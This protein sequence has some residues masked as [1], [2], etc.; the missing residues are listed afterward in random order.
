MKKFTLSILCV[1]S[2][3]FFSCSKEEIKQQKNNKSVTAEKNGILRFSSKSDL[4]NQLAEISKTNDFSQ[5]QKWHLTK[6]ST[7]G[8]F[9]SLRDSLISE[10]LSKLSIDDINQMHVNGLILDPEDS[11]IADP[12]FISVLNKY[13]TIIVG[14]K[15]Y[16][17]V[18][19]GVLVCDEKDVSI[20]YS[21]SL[22]DIPDDKD[23]PS[24]EDLVI[25]DNVDFIPLNYNDPDDDG[26]VYESTADQNL[27]LENG[28]SVSKNNIHSVVYASSGGDASGFQKWISSI[29]GLNVTAVNHYDSNHRMK[30]RMYSQDYLIYRAV[31][32]TVRM[33]TKAIGIWWRKNAEEFRYGWSAIEV[34]YKVPSSLFEIPNPVTGLP[35]IKSI[36]PYIEKPFPYKNQ[37]ITL[38]HVPI[39][40]YSITG[41]NINTAFKAGVNAITGV[42]QSYYNTFTNKQNN[43]SGIFTQPSP[44][45]ILI[46]YPQGEEVALN[47]GREVVRWD[48]T[49]FSGNFVV[50]TSLNIG[51]GSFNNPELK[52]ISTSETAIKRGEI[53]AAVKYNGEWRAV[54]IF[55]E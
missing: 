40:N 10:K 42:I 47:E 3:I 35:N 53:Y 33:Q 50:G 49:P 20:L 46:T 24:P 39:L 12:Y 32:M 51:T 9:V 21:L 48:F 36:P 29:F 13:R 52:E 18:K 55:T 7:E 16:R 15:A 23:N 54:K 38:F 44:E 6:S 2:I 4:K 8:E 25:P 37:E 17:F 11:I 30:V 5:V 45:S 1:L 14:N 28:V 41:G 26:Y 22:E 27:M 43:V 31:G 19:N 34:E